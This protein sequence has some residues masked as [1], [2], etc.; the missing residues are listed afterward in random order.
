VIRP[1]MVLVL[2]ATL[3]AQAQDVRIVIE[4]ATGG[5]SCGKWTNTP[6]KSAEHEIFKKW[7]LG[8]VSGVNFESASGDFLQGRDSDG[9]TAWID[10]YCRT[11]PLHG[12][13]QA[14]VE[15]VRALRAGR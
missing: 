13:T 2:A 4:P 15:L 11:N 9:L 12:M 5:L 14:A 10:N 6:R 8:F 3:A 1:A 7:L